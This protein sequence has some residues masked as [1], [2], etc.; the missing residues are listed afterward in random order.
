M[1][2]KVTFIIVVLITLA[3]FT[4][5]TQSSSIIGSIELVDVVICDEYLRFNILIK[6]IGETNFILYKPTLE[7]FCNEDIFKIYLTETSS[8]KR[9]EVFPC[10][11]VS[12]VD[13]INLNNSCSVCLKHGEGFS[14]SYK[15]ELKHITPFIGKGTYSVMVY[16]NT[17]EIHFESNFDNVFKGALISKKLIVVY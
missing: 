12:Q 10:D 17:S 16:Y 11:Y 4:G 6:N 5:K 2:S 7:D 1:L 3:S 15:V 14:K 13:I 9:H 8:N